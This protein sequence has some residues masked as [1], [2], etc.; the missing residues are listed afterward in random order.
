[1]TAPRVLAAAVLL[2][3]GACSKPTATHDGEGKGAAAEMHT[4]APTLGDV[5]VQVGRRF[6][7]MGRAAAAN[8]FELAAFEAGELEELFEGD[9]PR[10]QLPKEGPTQQ[11]GALAKQFLQAIPPE[12]TK[13]AEAKDKTAFAAA[14]KHAATLCN[15]CHAA[16]AKGFIEVPESP[17]Q[18]VPVLDALP[19]PTPGK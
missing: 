5:M 15:G 8:R 6:E 12:L 18:A 10:A 17:G 11:I 4:E 1:M 19:G 3:L 13:A 2:V 9:V 7:V 14:F 16:S